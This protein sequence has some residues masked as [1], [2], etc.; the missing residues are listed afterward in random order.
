MFYLEGESERCSPIVCKQK[1]LKL[2]GPSMFVKI[3][4]IADLVSQLTAWAK[5]KLINRSQEAH[6]LL[7]IRLDKLT[8]DVEIEAVIRWS[9]Q[10]QHILG[11]AMGIWKH[12]IPFVESVFH[13]SWSTNSFFS[14]LILDLAKHLLS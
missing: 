12:R 8:V 5:V 9:L 6:K 11:L 4:S 3:L 10:G 2:Q 7:S 14:V 1:K 13:S